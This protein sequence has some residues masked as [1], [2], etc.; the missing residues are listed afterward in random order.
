[1]AA[2]I[3]GQTDTNA[4]TLAAAL[5]GGSITA[6]THIFKEGSRAAI[7][8]SPEPV[9]NLA[10]SLVEDAAVIGGLW[11]AVRHPFIF[12]T[13]LTLFV[14]LAAWSIPKIIG[15]VFGTMGRTIGRTPSPPLGA[16]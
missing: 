7:N 11:L 10:V 6:G 1:L 9:S 15:F 12:M 14:L 8:T 5:L 16:R 13:L 3:I 4:W 2:G